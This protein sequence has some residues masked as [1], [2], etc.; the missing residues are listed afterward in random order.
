MLGKIALLQVDF[1]KADHYFNE[2]RRLD[3]AITCEVSAFRAECA[4]EYLALSKPR[5]ANGQQ[6][7]AS[8]KDAAQGIAL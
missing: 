4:E 5:G 3:S 6:S 1:A 8:K 7:I 2:A